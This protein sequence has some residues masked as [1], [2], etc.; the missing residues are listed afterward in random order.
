[1][2]QIGH[3]GPKDWPLQDVSVLCFV[4]QFVQERGKSMS[5]KKVLLTF[6]SLFVL[7]APGRAQVNDEFQR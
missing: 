6:A 4:R 5:F 3:K 2:G 1:M 7:F